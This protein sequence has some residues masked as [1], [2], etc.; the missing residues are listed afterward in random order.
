MTDLIDR[1]PS[2]RPVDEAGVLDY[3]NRE[4]GPAIRAAIQRINRLILRVE[5]TTTPEPSSGVTIDWS[6]RSVALL[7]LTSSAD[8][9][10]IAPG[11]DGAQLELVIGYTGAYTVGW[12]AGILWEG[13]AP[14]VLS[15][16]LGLI[17]RISF[18]YAGSNYLGH[19]RLA[20]T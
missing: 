3:L 1:L 9:A 7:G 8:L 11:V 16:A 14:P 13:G 4:A 20:Y 6:T 5:G 18:L 15:S 10:F 19:A 2:G 12:P 17:D